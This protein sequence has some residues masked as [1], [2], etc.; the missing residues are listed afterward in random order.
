MKGPNTDHMFIKC[1]FSIPLGP[2]LH[3]QWEAKG[4]TLTSCSFR[5]LIIWVGFFFPI[6]IFF[7]LEAMS[8]WCPWVVSN[9][10]TA[11]GVESTC[12]VL[13]QTGWEA[14]AGCGGG[15]G[16]GSHRKGLFCLAGRGEMEREEA[17]LPRLGHC[18]RSGDQ[19]LPGFSCC[20]CLQVEPASHA[21]AHLQ[22]LTWLSLHQ[23]PSPL[24]TST[25]ALALSR[26]CSSGDLSL[27]LPAPCTRPTV[28]HSST[29]HSV[30]LV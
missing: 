27:S 25:N 19:G 1:P 30:L 24:H 8:W 20:S 3:H 18:R 7:N 13:A 14:N 16:S 23:E 2:G 15:D 12:P 28:T 9:L 17:Q 6:L 10:V 29:L 5:P 4:P 26:L 11:P 22:A 21:V